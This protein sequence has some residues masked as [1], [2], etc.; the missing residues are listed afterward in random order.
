MN[1]REAAQEYLRETP[2]I[3]LD[4]ARDLAARLAE[5]IATRMSQRDLMLDRESVSSGL[6]EILLATL[7]AP[8]NVFLIAG[9]EDDNQARLE[10]TQCLLAYAD[11]PESAGRLEIEQEYWGDIVDLTSGDQEVWPIQ[12]NWAWDAYWDAEPLLSVRHT[13]RGHMEPRR[14]L[15]TVGSVHGSFGETPLPPSEDLV[16]LDVI[17]LA[18]YRALVQHPELLKTLEWRMFEKLLADALDIFGY[19]VELQR[20]TKDGGVDIFAIRS[21]QFGQHRYILQAK[22][23]SHRVS[24]EPVRQLLF[25]HNHHRATKSCLATT[26]SFTKGAWELASQYRWQLDLRDWEGIQNWICEAA[27]LKRGNT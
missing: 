3:W 25:L 10:I 8:E 23:W 1:L 20:G 17:D 12:R 18:L 24:V 22:R 7:V 21:D 13:V 11:D 27:R 26:S 4:F 14:L 19:H 6:S 16:R 15:K 5:D 9:A 2:E